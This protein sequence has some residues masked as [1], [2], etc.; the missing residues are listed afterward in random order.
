MPPFAALLLL[1]FA[2]GAYAF[3]PYA[4]MPIRNARMRIANGNILP[5]V[6][7]SSQPVALGYAAGYL[8]LLLMRVFRHVTRGMK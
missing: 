2:H 4:L 1:A 6:E 8:M 3:A 7:W 5:L